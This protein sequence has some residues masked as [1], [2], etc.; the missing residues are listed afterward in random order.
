MTTYS[1]RLSYFAKYAAGY[2]PC[3]HK[4]RLASKRAH[5]CQVCAIHEVRKAKVL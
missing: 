5:E 3:G 1:R 2:L 4:A